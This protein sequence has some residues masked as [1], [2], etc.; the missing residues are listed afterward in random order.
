MRLSSRALHPMPIDCADG[1]LHDRVSLCCAMHVGVCLRQ[2][3]C[4][5]NEVVCNT[6]SDVKATDSVWV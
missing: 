5:I 2:C 3:L 6:D 1:Y 4:S